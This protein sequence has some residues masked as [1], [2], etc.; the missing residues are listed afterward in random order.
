MV[1]KLP[2]DKIVFIFIEGP[3]EES[4]KLLAAGYKPHALKS[5]PAI[6]LFAASIPPPASFHLP[7]TTFA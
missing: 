5:L 3:F 1:K 4:H 6:F 2:Q 7:L